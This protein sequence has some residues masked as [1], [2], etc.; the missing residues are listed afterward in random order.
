M[1]QKGVTTTARRRRVAAVTRLTAMR[2]GFRVLEVVAPAAAGSRAFTLWCTLPD[3]AGRRKDFRPGEGTLTRVPAPRGGTVAVESWGPDDAPLVYLVHGWGGWRG[4]L[5]AFVAPLVER[6]FRVVALDAPSH[7]DSDPGVLGPG[8]GTLIEAVESLDAV[9][10]AFG[11]AAGVIAHSMGCT[12]AAMALHSRLAADRLV[13]IAPN[14]D[15]DVITADFVRLVGLSERTRLLMHKRVEHFVDRPISDFDLV[16]LG[17]DG[18]L[19]PTLVVHDRLDKETPY[20]V[21]RQVAEAWPE[22]TLISTHGLG[23]QRILTDPATIATIVDDLASAGVPWANTE[24][25]R[26]RRR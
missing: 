15:V 5:G 24:A 12:A 14:P 11:P 26:E 6:G 4:Q 9:A 22:A 2:V 7:G 23:H 8:R 20:A 16:P 21:G 17:T 25:R 3:N 1:T 10:E 19:P 18:S 13:L